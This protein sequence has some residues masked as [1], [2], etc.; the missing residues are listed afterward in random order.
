MQFMHGFLLYLLM[1]C[2]QILFLFRL[3]FFGCCLA[4]FDEGLDFSGVF[5]SLVF[6]LLL[7]GRWLCGLV[8]IREYNGA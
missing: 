3:G 1:R 6:C 5:D 7:T 8:S 2:S 4:L